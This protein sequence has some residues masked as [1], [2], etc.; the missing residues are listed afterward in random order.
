MSLFGA[1]LLLGT[2]WAICKGGTIYEQEAYPEINDKEFD[3]ECAVHGIMYKMNDE[4]IR[5]FA[6]RW[7]VRYKDRQ[8]KILPNIH[9][10]QDYR[11]DKYIQDYAL[12]NFEIN[13]FYGWWNSYN[14]RMR[15]NKSK[16]IKKR[17]EYTY[18]SIKNEVKENIKENKSIVKFGSNYKRGGETFRFNDSN[19]R[20]VLE[21][22]HWSNLDH[23]EVVRRM[24]KIRNETFLGELNLV[25][26]K[27]ILRRRDNGWHETWQIRALSKS[28]AKSY[29]KICSLHFGW[30]PEI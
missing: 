8:Y 29:Y 5:K 12:D 30:D 11:I 10:H 16:I 17:S 21:F 27:P 9:P 13:D 24:D 15:E 3:Q 26:G 6:A 25:Y 18:D 1:A 14:E 28:S 20:E 22:V 23:D 4:K 7:G 19:T 2:A